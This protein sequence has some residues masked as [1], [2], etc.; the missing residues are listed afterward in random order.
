M[1]VMVEIIEFWEGGLGW[2]GSNDG[3]RGIR[4]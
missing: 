2:E 1:F 3:P 4:A